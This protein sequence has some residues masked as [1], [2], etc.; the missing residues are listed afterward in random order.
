MCEP[1]TMMMA[2][3]AMSA[4][5]TMSSIS[6]AKSQAKAEFE[7]AEAQRRLQETENNRQMSEQQ[8]QGLEQQSEIVRSA[9]DELGKFQAGESM[10]SQS[11]LGSLL[12]GQSYLEQV[13]LGRI[14]ESTA[15]A[16]GALKA[17]TGAAIQTQANR[18]AAASARASAQI[19]QAVASFVKSGVSAGNTYAN[20]PKTPDPVFWP[21]T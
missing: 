18:G 17:N 2:G 6:S 7:A 4:V 3:L 14:D 13:G 15:R 21:G 19:G 11:T 9:R 5:Q 12:F 8:Q 10:A 16:E 20:L 1:I